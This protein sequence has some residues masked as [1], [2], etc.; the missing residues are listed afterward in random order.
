MKVLLTGAFGN[1]GVSTLEELLEQGHTVRCFDLKTKANE[2]T[3]RRYGDRIEV[4]WGDLRNPADVAAAVQG[5][6]AV[7]HLAF[8]IPKMSVTG[9]ESEDRPEWAREINV[10]GTRNLITAMETLP[11][12]P[13]FV[14]ASSYHVYGRTQHQ[15]PPRTVADPVDPVEHYSQ[16]K[17]ECE[18]M[19]KASRLQ[20]AILRLSAT[21]PIA[22][23]MDPG[24]FD[25]PLGNRME[26]VH[27]RDVGLAMANAISSEDIWGETLLIGGGPACQLYYHEI[28]ERVLGAMGLG[29]LPDEA[30]GDVPFCT[31]WV[32][33]AHSQQRLAYQ[34]RTFDTYIEDMT[35][36]AGAKRHVFRLFRPLARLWLLGK[37]R[38]FQ[39]ARAAGTHDGWRDK[40]AVIT[41]ASSGIGA[42]T[43]RRLARA[44][45]RVVL[46]ARREER[47]NDL[48]AELRALG[49]EVLVIP[50][51]LADED[52]HVRVF[53][54]VRAAY[55]SADVLVNNAG[56]GWYGF[57]SDMPWAT[58]WQM[59]QVNVVATVRLTLL[60]MEDMKARNSGRIIN[61]GSIVGSLPSQGVALYGATKSFV[62]A[63]TTALHRE[64][65]GTN[66]HVSVVR[67]GAVKTEFYDKA[68]EHTSPLYKLAERAGI[69][70]ELVAERIWGLLKRP[71]RVAYV[72]WFLGFVPWVE[73]SFG[74]L[75]DLLGPLLLRRGQKV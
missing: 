62:D 51:D 42:A 70:A 13:R 63:F 59:L 12:P 36:L 72:P 55:G 74:W 75:I 3:A 69:K 71:A 11:T 38:Y 66:V 73:L 9:V 44:G 4:A 29:M 64:L 19:I 16:H 14:F 21:L 27:T 7:I 65:R 23:Q 35:E 30:F 37:S 67:S 39:A 2:K 61:V 43:A 1:V 24:M 45:M 26:F 41:G 32:D 53:N 40:V 8:I 22:I 20:W 46:V 31:D 52:E 47:L 56:L 50:A 10:G 58:A 17:V 25:V 57:G 6:D 5:Q 28:V 48:A 49:G 18:Q 68:T 54:E 34:Q 33:T 15:P 60:F